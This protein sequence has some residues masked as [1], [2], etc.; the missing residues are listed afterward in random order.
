MK[1]SSGT[2]IEILMKLR[3]HFQ[4]NTSRDKD[5]LE[6]PFRAEIYSLEALAQHGKVVA[7]KHKT[8]YGKTKESLLNRLDNNEG[9]LLQVRDLMV[10]SIRFGKQ[11][12]PAA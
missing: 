6:E 1:I 4:Y 10:K 11:V 9:K 5:N 12:T 8:S 2:V 7:Q 3:S